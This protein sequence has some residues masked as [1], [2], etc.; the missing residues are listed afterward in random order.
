MAVPGYGSTVKFGVAAAEALIPGVVS[1]TD[2]GAE[3]E[4][5]DA[6]GL[7]D[8]YQQLRAGRTQAPTVT[9]V[10]HYSAIGLPSASPASIPSWYTTNLIILDSNAVAISTRRAFIDGSP[11]ISITG[12]ATI[13]VTYEFQ[14][15]NVF[16]Q[17]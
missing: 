16:D 11:A 2:N 8:D 9:V 12:E 1:I 10:C 15:E 17:S 7:D 3:R 4:K 13:E 5:I 14:C 6:T